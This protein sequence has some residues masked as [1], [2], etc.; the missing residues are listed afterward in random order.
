MSNLGAELRDQAINQVQRNAD[1]DWFTEAVEAVRW[2]S[3]ITLYFTTDDVWEY[4]KMTS[5]ELST[6]DNRAMGAVMKFCQKKKFVEPTDDYWQSKRP[7]A[8]ARPIRVWKSIIY[9]GQKG[10]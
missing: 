5:P 4:L 2:I 1:A 8:H 10:L 7:Q 9:Y 3:E 6:H